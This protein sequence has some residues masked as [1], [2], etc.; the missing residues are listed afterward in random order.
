MHGLPLLQTMFLAPLPHAF[1]SS[2]VCVTGR[3]ALLP[4]PRPQKPNRQDSGKSRLSAHRH[5]LPL[6]A[7][8]AGLRAPAEGECLAEQRMDG[9]GWHACDRGST[10]RVQSTRV[11]G[12]APPH[13]LNSTLCS[14]HPACLSVCIRTSSAATCPGT[15]TPWATLCCCAPTACPCTT[16]AWCVARCGCTCRVEVDPG[17]PDAGCLHASTPS[18]LSASQPARMHACT[19]ACT[20]GCG[21]LQ[22]RMVR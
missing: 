17:Q 5:F 3:A 18:C 16:S 1:T 22:G 20:A 14:L 2:R 13:P 21:D 10:D 19:D 11:C 6:A 4:L 7:C 12:A 9:R 15:P 8:C